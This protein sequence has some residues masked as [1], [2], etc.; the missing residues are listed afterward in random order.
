MGL[1]HGLKPH[2]A[3]PLQMCANLNITKAATRPVPRPYL[4]QAGLT[5]LV[6]DQA[7]LTDGS[8]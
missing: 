6:F 4:G 8:E 5:W 7:F 2:P 3:A 1:D